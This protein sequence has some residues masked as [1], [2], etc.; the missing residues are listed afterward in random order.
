MSVHELASLRDRIL[1]MLR[2]AGQEWSYQAGRDP[3]QERL[4]VG[5]VLMVHTLREALDDGVE[6]YQFLRGDEDYKMRFAD[7]ALQLVTVARGLTGLG[8]LAAA[9]GAGVTRLP[10][11]M[12]EPVRRGLAH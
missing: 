10:R 6:S 12:Q 9:A 4:R 11:P 1:P 8:R 2:F 5:F 3:G 7:D